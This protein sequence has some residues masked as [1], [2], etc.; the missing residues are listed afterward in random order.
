[1]GYTE[2]ISYLPH[3]H[4]FQQVYKYLLFPLC[5]VFV[6]C[7]F[8]VQNTFKIVEGGWVFRAEDILEFQ[9][10]IVYGAAKAYK[11]SILVYLAQMVS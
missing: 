6:C 3:R 9:S 5:E 11:G 7:L 8:Y 1:M 10:L 4:T 2:F